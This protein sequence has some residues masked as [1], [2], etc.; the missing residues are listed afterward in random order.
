MSLVYD[1]FS[2]SKRI[3]FSSLKYSTKNDHDSLAHKI[4]G[5]KIKKVCTLVLEIKKIQLRRN[6]TPNLCQKTVDTSDNDPKNQKNS[7]F[8]NL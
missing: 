3:F 2:F 5:S 8:I 4:F 7:N 6:Y 1:Q